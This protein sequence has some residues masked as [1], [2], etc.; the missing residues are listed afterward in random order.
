M[1]E[2]SPCDWYD[3]SC[4]DEDHSTVIK[5]GSNNITATFSSYFLLNFDKLKIL[6]LSNNTL[7]RNMDVHPTEAVADID[8]SMFLNLQHLTQV[9]LA[10]N[11]LSGEAAMLFAPLLE[12]GNVSYN[13][14]TSVSSTF[15]HMNSKIL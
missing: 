8:A 14:F 7:W 9:N 12:H 13:N 2:S 4:D 15:Y 11:N 6:D 5:M 1:I 3:T 10:Q